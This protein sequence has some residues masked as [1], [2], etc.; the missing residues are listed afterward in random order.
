MQKESSWQ[1]WQDFSLYSLKARHRE[2]LESTF[3]YKDISVVIIV[4]YEKYLTIHLA[5]R[6]V[7][8]FFILDFSIKSIRE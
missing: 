6:L 5:F 8:L 1:A 3:F 4:H 2:G 7:I